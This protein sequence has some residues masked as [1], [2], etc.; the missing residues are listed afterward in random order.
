MGLPC[1]ALLEDMEKGGRGSAE[2]VSG[3]GTCFSPFLSLVVVMGLGS[4]GRFS[5]LVVQINESI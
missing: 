1:L 5:G 2:G 3:C 4:T